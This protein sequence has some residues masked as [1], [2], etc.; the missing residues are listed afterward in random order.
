[1]DNCVA[2]LWCDDTFHT[3]KV[4]IKFDTLHCG[5]GVI[6]P[7]GYI[8]RHVLISVW[9]LKTGGDFISFN[10]KDLVETSF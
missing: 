3:G 6:P 10:K 7:E 4:L 2:L 5:R 8:F 1:M 9:N